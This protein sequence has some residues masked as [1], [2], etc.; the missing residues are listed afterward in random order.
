MSLR[1][2]VYSAGSV[3]A[4]SA[5]VALGWLGMWHAVLKHNQIVREV[6]LGEAADDT[7]PAT[8]NKKIK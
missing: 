6:L 5:I 7:K 3:L 1:A 4:V 2:V 8:E